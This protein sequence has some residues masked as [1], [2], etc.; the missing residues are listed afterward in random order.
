M[1]P[2]LF[3][4][5]SGSEVDAGVGFVV[6]PSQWAGGPW[7]A[8]AL[9]GG[10]VNVLCTAALRPHLDAT[11]WVLNRVTI[12][13]LKP[14]PKTALAVRSDVRR[15]GRRLM[16]IDVTVANAANGDVVA[17]ARAVLKQ[18]DHTPDPALAVVD[19]SDAHE[20]TPRTDLAASAF[21]DPEQQRFLPP[22]FH[23]TVAL[24]ISNHRADLAAWLSTSVDECFAGD[25]LTPLEHCVA[26]SDL[27]TVLSGRLLLLG[28]DQAA[29]SMSFMNTDTTVQLT[30]QPRGRWVG[31][32]DPSLS[33]VR[34]LGVS[35]VL[36]HDDDGL[37]GR[38][39]QSVISV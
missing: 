15:H 35:S 28:A 31:F 8:T 7:S 33:L 13:L 4:L 22:G 29:P 10:P 26:L 32:T 30:R 1:T 36:L 39:T 21:I 19:G 9:H 34:G 3:A 12:D 2:H 38:A 24:H 27:A 11:Q 18:P 5:T 25:R 23:S 20:A 14:V 16:M 6:E 37:I 17:M